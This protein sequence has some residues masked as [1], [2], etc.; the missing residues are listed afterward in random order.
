[1]STITLLTLD[2]IKHSAKILKK[3]HPNLTRCQRIDI[4]AQ[5]ISGLRNYHQVR[6]A[7]MAYLDSLITVEDRNLCT[8]AYCELIFDNSLKEDVKL[9]HKFHLNV[10]KA[11]AKPLR[12]TLMEKFILIKKG[13]DSGFE[14]ESKW[15]D[16]C[17]IKS[18][19]FIKVTERSRFSDIHW[20]YINF[21]VSLD[22]KWQDFRIWDVALELLKRF[23]NRRSQLMGSE[24]V[25]TIKNI[26]A[27][28]ASEIANQLFEAINSKVI[29]WL[30][31]TKK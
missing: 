21:P 6:K 23:G 22:A 26:E 12:Q 3:K 5:E 18:I 20:D 10:E 17:R 19:P 16:M 4:A 14:K 27:K 8:C 11:S 25:I 31:N 1:M 30:A 7:C 9:H 15:F 28:Y 29:E 13:K 24:Y 2:Q